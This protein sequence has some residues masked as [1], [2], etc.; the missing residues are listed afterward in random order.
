[1]STINKK[2]NY[3]YYCSVEGETEQWY[4]KWLS[5]IINNSDLNYTVKIEA[6]IQKNPYKHAKTLNFLSKC[7]DNME[8][9][10]ISD[11]EGCDEVHDKEFKEVIDNINRVKEMGKSINYFFGYSNLTF[12]LWIILH[13]MKYKTTLYNRHDYYKVIN[14]CFSEEF[15]SNDEFKHESNFKRCLKKLTIDDVV[16]AVNNANEIMRDKVNNCVKK[17]YYNGFE[18][19]EDNPALEVYKFVEKILRDCGKIM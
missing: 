11:Y 8:V 17:S 15:N 13:K 14:K 10:H 7:S 1:M 4:F 9:Y 12:E 16:S 19:Y 5:E 6:K 2:Q 3:Q 18:Y